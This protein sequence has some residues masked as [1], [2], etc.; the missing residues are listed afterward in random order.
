MFGRPE[1]FKPDSTAIDSI[2]WDPKTEHAKV[3]YKNNPKEYTFIVSKEEWKQVKKAPSVGQVVEHVWKRFNRSD[4]H[5]INKEGQ[6]RMDPSSGG[7]RG[8]PFYQSSKTGSRNIQPSNYE[9]K[10][11]QEKTPLPKYDYPKAERK[12]FVNPK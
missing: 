12:K 5:D 11:N 3:R 9:K 8:K 7:Y 10:A 1:K 6:S 4:V 2:E